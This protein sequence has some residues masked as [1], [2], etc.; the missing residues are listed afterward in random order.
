MD[1]VKKLKQNKVRKIGREDR[2]FKT[3]HFLSLSPA[4][5]WVGTR[6]VKQ[7][8]PYLLHFKE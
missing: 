8:N 1:E 2:R 3:I 6:K 4:E 7:N 5:G